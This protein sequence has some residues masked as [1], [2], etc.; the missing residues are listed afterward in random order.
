MGMYQAP[1]ERCRSCF[2]LHCNARAGDAEASQGLNE[3]QGDSLKQI[4]T[5]RLD[6][7]KGPHPG[8]PP[9]DTMLKIIARIDQGLE[10]ST[11]SLISR[12]AHSNMHFAPTV[13]NW[14]SDA[15]A[16]RSRWVSGDTMVKIIARIDQGLEVC[17]SM[18]AGAAHQPAHTCCT[19][20]HQRMHMSSAVPR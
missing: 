2:A 10:V 20:M 13:I 18:Y 4:A 19:S 11:D 12:L 16:C 6:R 9:G 8:W 15:E 3:D 7:I 5:K 14:V 17:I 1:N